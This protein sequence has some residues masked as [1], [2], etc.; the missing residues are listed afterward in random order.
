MSKA[1]DAANKAPVAATLTGVETLTNKT[2]DAPTLLLGG[3]QG[4]LNQVPVSQGPGQP[5]AW[6]AGGIATGKVYFFTSF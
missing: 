3:T 4:L 6:G 5:M 2:L 1:R